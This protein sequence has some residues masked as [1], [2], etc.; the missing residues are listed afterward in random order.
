MFRFEFI[1]QS[2]S[3]FHGLLRMTGIVLFFIFLVGYIIHFIEPGAF[4]TFFDGVWWAIVT[5]STVGY[6]DFV[7]ESVIGRILGMLLIISG[8]ALFS[9]F[10]SNLASS[11]VL[12]RQD[13][14]KGGTSYHK[15]GHYII[16]GWNERSQQLIK[17]IR[18]IN[19]HTK[20]I[21]IDESLQ[22]RPEECPNVVFVKGSPTIDETF[23]R[24]NAKEAHTVIITA[25]LHINEKVADANS[26][27]TLLT[28]KGIQPA[29]Y[30]I[31]ELVT[32]NQ[33]KNAERAG[34]DE[35]IQS[36]NYLSLLMINGI[37][38]HGMTDVI[39]QMLRHEKQD[40]LSFE[41]LRSE[42]VNE[43]FKKAIEECQT[44]DRFLIG[45]RRDNE[46]ILHPNKGSSLL[47]GDILIFFNR[48]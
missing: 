4:P 2:Y 30:S 48:I 32:P 27:L 20:L 22:E 42:L 8:I 47:K 43:S 1:V 41:P 10:I 18:K 24:A 7:P 5:I 16:V 33:I 17:E 23:I 15:S 39:S 6:G 35:I 13:R 45:I 11:T 31:V 14:E 46:T 3:K 12:A 36:S 38:Y 28:V 40:Q 29:I 21:L 34:A 37:L 9:F 19:S 26:V 44:E 25:N